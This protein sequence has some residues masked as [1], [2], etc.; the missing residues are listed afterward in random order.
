[1]NP[2]TIP[3]T[4][5]P[6]VNHLYRRR[7]SKV[8]RSRAY[9]TWLTLNAI[10]IGPVTPWT[11]YPCAVRLT[12]HGGKGWPPT[13]DLDNAL[14]ATLDLL[15]HLGILAED[16]SKHIHAVEVLYIPPASPKTTAT[17]ECVIYRGGGRGSA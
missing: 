1:M 6:S 12:I 13:R 8:F 17:A 2:L 10:L 7:G 11:A 4:I 5:P 15:R 16:N 14:K 3:L 9:Q